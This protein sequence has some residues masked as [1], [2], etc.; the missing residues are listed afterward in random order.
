MAPSATIGSITHGSTTDNTPSRLW[1]VPEPRHNSQA[2][3]TNGAP[4][5][6]AMLPSGMAVSEWSAAF[7]V[8]P[9]ARPDAIAVGMK[10]KRAGFHRCGQFDFDFDNLEVNVFAAGGAQLPAPR[11]RPDIGDASIRQAFDFQYAAR[12][13]P[14]RPQDGTPWFSICD[15]GPYMRPFVPD[16][17]VSVHTDFVRGV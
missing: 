8:V 17:Q 3:F 13:A 15:I 6:G 9:L 5:R 1:E 7:G 2:G 12:D 14:Q 10:S 11:P 4:K 16:T